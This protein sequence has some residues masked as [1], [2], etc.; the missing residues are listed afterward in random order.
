MSGLVAIWVG[1]WSGGHHVHTLFARTKISLFVTTLTWTM[2]WQWPHRSD[3]FSGLPLKD[4]LVWGDILQ[5]DTCS[6]LLTNHWFTHWVWRMGDGITHKVLNFN[7][8]I[9]ISGHPVLPSDEVYTSLADVW[10]GGRGSSYISGG[11]RG[12]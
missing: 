5:A 2:G 6:T 7:Q 12:E 1:P 9:S 11:N 8:W 10:E 3:Q 4:F